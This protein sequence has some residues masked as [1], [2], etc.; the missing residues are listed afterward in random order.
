MGERITPYRNGMSV[1]ERIDEIVARGVNVHFEMMDGG[2]AFLMVGGDAFWLRAKK[3]KLIASWHE[4]RDGYG[5]K[6]IPK[7]TREEG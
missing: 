1:E 3:G 4:Y 2:L 5:A 6:P 7:E